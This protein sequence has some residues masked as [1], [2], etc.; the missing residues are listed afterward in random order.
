[1]KSMQLATPALLLILIV[2]YGIFTI[3]L[4]QENLPDTTIKL[5]DTSTVAS[6][7]TVRVTLPDTNSW[8]ICVGQIFKENGDPINLFVADL[9]ERLAAQTG[10]G[11]AVTR[12]EFV[13]LL[14]QMEDDTVYTSQL[15]KYATPI[16]KK[17][18]DVAHA[19]YASKVMKP[20]KY[21]AGIEFYR[22]HQAI[23]ESAAKN[24]GVLPKDI[25][26]ILMWE[27]A[28]GKYTGKYRIFNVFLGQ[29]LF[30]EPAE[31]IALHRLKI[32][33]DSVALAP[34][35]QKARFNRLRSGAVKNA[36]VLVRVAKETGANPFAQLG[37]WG[38]AI[39]YVQF[40]P[41]SL[42]FAVDADSNGVINLTDWPDAI[43]SVANYLQQS[44][45]GKTP[46][47]RKRAIFAY[48]RLDSYVNGVMNYA[49]STWNRFEKEMQKTDSFATDSTT[50]RP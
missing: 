42:R 3:G 20:A 47:R 21:Q 2:G 34:P 24:F 13:Q 33:G 35:D 32:A 7:D 30:L 8:R 46:S 22:Q 19:S 23:F 43:H 10:A 17:I 48:N 14:Q 50:T 5:P 37:S 38:G 28:L 25:L 31:Q 27:S 16:S 12:E 49:D 26:G 45:Y 6:S 1:M 44:G 41:A 29:I 15:I 9:L 4:A 39:G 36:A 18:Q 40:M 11:K